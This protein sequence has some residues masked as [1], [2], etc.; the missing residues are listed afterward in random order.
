MMTRLCYEAKEKP[1]IL[2]STTPG[3]IHRALLLEMPDG[4]NPCLLFLRHLTRRRFIF[5]RQYSL[6]AGG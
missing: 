1:S 6:F 2:F 4:S 5:Q 3:E